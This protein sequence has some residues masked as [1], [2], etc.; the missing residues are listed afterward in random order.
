MSASDFLFISGATGPNAAAINGGYI[1]ASEVNGGHALYS[2]RCD[3]GMCMQH[4]VGIWQVKPVTL[5]GTAACYAY[6]AGGC[7]AE[8]CTSR[9]WKVTDGATFQDAPL[10]I[11]VSESEVSCRF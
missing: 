5:K 1:R 11:M 9:P 10:V 6:V 3:P 2:K 4:V 8:D 7:A